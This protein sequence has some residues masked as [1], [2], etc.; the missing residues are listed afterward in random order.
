MKLQ[1]NLVSKKYSAPKSGGENQAQVPTSG[2]SRLTVFGLVQLDSSRDLDS[3]G[4]EEIGGFPRSSGAQEEPEGRPRTL[5]SNVSKSFSPSFF[6]SPLDF[7]GLAS[8]SCWVPRQSI[9]LTQSNIRA[10]LMSKP[11]Y[12]ALFGLVLAPRRRWYAHDTGTSLQLSHYQLSVL[13]RPVKGLI[14]AS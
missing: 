13:P 6:T 11:A 5:P 14:K 12:L 1:Q 8:D 4:F 10:I 3:D 7:C 9:E 2:D